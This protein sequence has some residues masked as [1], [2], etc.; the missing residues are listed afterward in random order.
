MRTRSL[1]REERKVQMLTA[2]TVA[3]QS[4]QDDR[5]TVYDIARKLGLRAST[6]LRIM[7]NELVAE[8]YLESEREYI[9]TGGAV[10]YKIIYSLPTYSPYRKS[11]QSAAR[12]SREI[13]INHRGR[14]VGQGR[15]F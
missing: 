13:A 12:H 14:K 10:Q 1:G 8:G 6:N 5:M 7:L 2:F 3:I 15:L 9:Q 11:P 4:E